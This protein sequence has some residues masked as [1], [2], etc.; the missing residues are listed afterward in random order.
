MKRFVKLAGLGLGLYIAILGVLFLFAFGSMRYSSLA[1]LERRV[2]PS[3]FVFWQGGEFYRNPPLFT[4]EMVDTQGQ[5]ASRDPSDFHDVD[6]WVLLLWGFDDI[7][8]VSIAANLGLDVEE[9]AAKRPGTTVSTMNA[10]LHM[11]LHPVP[12]HVSRKRILILDA[13][14]LAATYRPE[15]LDAFVYARM[16]GQLGLE[17]WETC[18]RS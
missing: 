12:F 17:Q 2:N 10:A 1:T 7:R 3:T 16:I 4:Q 5:L 9:I 8:N 18:K 15:C 6:I 11:R 14:Y 13:Q